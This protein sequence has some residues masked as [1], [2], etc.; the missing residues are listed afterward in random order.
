MIDHKPLVLASDF[1]YLG[2]TVSST[3]KIDKEPRNRLGK[4]SA[5]FGKLQQ[6]LWNNRHVSIRVKCKVYRAVVLS[7]LLY[8]AEAW[9][10]CRTQVKN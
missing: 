2:S 6:R 7:C 9:T 5:A 3:A 8:G 4:A 10:I 1:T